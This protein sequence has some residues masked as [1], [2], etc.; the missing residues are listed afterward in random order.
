[1]LLLLGMFA[2]AAGENFCDRCG[3]AVVPGGAYCICCGKKL[4]GEV[5]TP[6]KETPN[7]ALAAKMPVRAPAVPEEIPAVKEPESMVA[8]PPVAAPAEPAVKKIE[9]KRDT[10]IKPA[11]VLLKE[12][13]TEDLHRVIKTALQEYRDMINAEREKER[14]ASLQEEKIKYKLDAIQERLD[15][16]DQKEKPKNSNHLV[17]GCIAGGVL[18]ILL[19]LISF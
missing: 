7:A 5:Q 13:T 18:I 3:T 2:A 14:G 17:V 15:T 4:Y 19:S 12:M 9:A 6:V 16:I 11:A 10:A 8:L 1:M